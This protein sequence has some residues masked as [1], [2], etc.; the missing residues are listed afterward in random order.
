M[1]KVELGTPVT[2][3]QHVLRLCSL[4]DWYRDVEFSVPQGLDSANRSGEK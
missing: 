2:C 1:Q 4:Q 3:V